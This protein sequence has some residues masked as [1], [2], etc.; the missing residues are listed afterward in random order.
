MLTQK[1]IHQTD[2]RQYDYSSWENENRAEYDYIVNYVE[3]NK[4]VLDLGC[5]NGSLMQRLISEKK[6]DVTGIE[7]SQSAVDVCRKKGLNVIKGR[8][9]EKLPFED[10]SFD[11]SVC[12][13]TL[14]MVMFPEKTISEM[15]RVSRFLIISFP[16]FAFY[17]NRL[18]LL[19][20]G[21]M[22]HSSLFGYKWYNT[23]HIHLF[24]IKDF[25]ELL[26]SI[27]NLEVIDH[28][29][30]KTGSNFKNSLMKIAPNFF[31]LI[32][33]MLVKKK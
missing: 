29:F 17:K 7:I 15:K 24:S 16:N 18:E 1:A 4:K 25:Y 20:R 13:V 11:Y 27:G 21:V 30:T 12:N 5:G 3:M 2:N 6:S 10:N 31:Q 19:F 14:Q 32:P 33:I 9:D 22:P 8:I 28:T 23:G 26:D